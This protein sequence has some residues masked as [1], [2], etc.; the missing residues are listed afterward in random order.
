MGKTMT[1][2]SVAELSGLSGQNVNMIPGTGRPSHLIDPRKK[3]KEWIFEMVKSIYNDYN[4]NCPYLFY[5]NRLHYDNIINAIQGIINQNK[6]QPLTDQNV[7]H[8]TNLTSVNHDKRVLNLLSKY[9]RLLLG[10]LNDVEFDITIKPNNSLAR[11]QN[12]EY[13]S[14]LSTF[15]Q[16][17]KILKDNNVG[18]IEDFIGQNGFDI[19]DN[20]EE[21]EIQ[22]QMSKPNQIAMFIKRALREINYLDKIDQKFAEADYNLLLGATAIEAVI[23]QNGVP[24]REVV[25]IRDLL[26]GFSNTEDFRDVSEIGKY[27]MATINDIRQEDKDG[28]LSMDD[29]KDIESHCMGRY[30]NDYSL[31]QGSMGSSR[32]DDLFG[33]YRSLMIDV[34]FYS[35]DE[36]VHIAKKDRNG[37]LRIQP[38]DHGYYKGR[39]NDYVVNHPDKKLYRT[40]TQNVYKATWIVG[41]KHIYNYGLVKNI[42]RPSTDI[43]KAE[44]PITLIAPLIKNGRTVSIIEEMLTIVERANLFWQKM[45]ESL[46]HARP[47]GFEIDVDSLMAAISGL[48]DQGYTFD[49]ALENMIEHNIVI[50]STKGM[51]GIANG[52]K[53]FAELAGGLGSD[54]GKYYEGLQGCIQLLQEISGFSSVAASSP[55]KYT[56]KKVAELAIQ[57]ADYSIKHLFRAKKTLYENVMQSSVR[58]LLDSITYGDSEILRKYIGDNAFD[59]IK[60][61]ANVYECMLMVEFRPT[62]EEWADIKEAANIALK[63]PLEQGGIAYPDYIRVVTAD[64]IEEA[65]QLMRLLYSRNIKKFQQQQIAMQ[66]TNGE[67]QRL[68]AQQAAQAQQQQ[69]AMQLE[70]EKQTIALQTRAALDLKHADFL[71]LVEEKKLEGLIKDDHLKTQGDID[72]GITE[73]EAKY[74]MDRLKQKEVVKKS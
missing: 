40:C 16:L 23:N 66:Q 32:G 3:G 71:Y 13:R 26:V 20:N 4:K 44:L 28:N 48:A 12:D 15:M 36:E 21:L 2:A 72:K 50:K 30:G 42:A 5:N 49:K 62:E 56:G 57:S 38:K 37:N 25:D 53:P 43:F 46:A 64:T 39:E 29:L 31:S 58:L 61:N 33:K 24:T 68:S 34:Y 1:M 14:I 67:Q 7:S 10:K 8:G 60:Q 65:E 6:Y 69:L 17:N 59:F 52:N 70:H 54:F 45:Q 41:T 35:Y 11:I 19:P 18:K 22:M 27:R 74:N 47:S 9:F 63:V 55:A 73:I 51:G